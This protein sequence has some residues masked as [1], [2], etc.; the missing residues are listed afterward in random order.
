[1]VTKPRSRWLVTLAAALTTAVASSVSLIL[2]PTAFADTVATSAVQPIASDSFG[3]TAATGWGSADVGGVWSLAGPSTLY[4]VGG[5][6]G[7]IT[8]SRA[9]QGPVSELKSVGPKR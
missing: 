1:M 2:V 3:R 5:G 7:T 8:M 4:S 9:A 6:V